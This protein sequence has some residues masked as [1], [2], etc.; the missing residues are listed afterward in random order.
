MASGM[1]GYGSA[2]F[3][4]SSEEG[5]EEN[6]FVEVKSLNS[7]YLEVNARIPER[8]SKSETGIRDLIKKG[9]SRGVFTVSVISKTAACNGLRLN[10]EVVRGYL[11]AQREIKEKFGVTGS[12]DAGL[13]L[14]LRDIFKPSCRAEGGADTEAPLLLK[15]VE[16]ALSELVLMRKKEGE[17]LRADIEARLASMEFRVSGIGKR[18]PE[19]IDRFRERLKNSMKELLAGKAM[20]EQR[21]LMEVGILAERA[22]VDEEL[23]RLRSHMEEMRRY[24]SLS[25]PT[26]RRLDFLCQ[27]LLREIN[28]IGSKISDAP[29]TMIVVELKGELE[30]IREQVQNIE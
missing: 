13:I 23:T 11:N 21:L 4:L 6:F 8:F 3:G 9:F 17:A 19:I 18:A 15:A 22:N 12:V 28:T 7:R 27:E 26:G 1:T 5:K 30:K 20:D 25:E 29:L 2:V 24:L 14:G 16:E 10:H